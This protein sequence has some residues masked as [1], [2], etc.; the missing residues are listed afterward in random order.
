M[1]HWLFARPCLS[2]Q[3]P[4]AFISFATFDEQ[5]EHSCSGTPC[6]L[7]HHPLWSSP[8]VSPAGFGSAFCSAFCSA[9]GFP[10]FLLH[11]TD[12]R[13]AGTRS[14]QMSPARS[15]TTCMDNL[16]WV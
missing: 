7:H 15:I 12:T 10:S 6:S 9:C 4:L 5:M 8:F 13:A 1:K 2:H 3:S 11:P 14:E 16:L